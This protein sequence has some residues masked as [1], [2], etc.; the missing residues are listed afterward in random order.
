MEKHA[1]WVFQ[2]PMVFWVCGTKI[3]R[4]EVGFLGSNPWFFFNLVVFLGLL[5]ALTSTLDRPRDLSCHHPSSCKNLSV[6][7]LSFYPNS[8]ATPTPT[9]NYLESLHPTSD[10]PIITTP[11]LGSRL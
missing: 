6:C 9:V 4:D 1:L 10:T 3:L 8:A 2:L 5:P 7:R 11:T